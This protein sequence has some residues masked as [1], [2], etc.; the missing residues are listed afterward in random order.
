MSDPRLVGHPGTG[1]RAERP[2]RWG[3]SSRILASDAVLSSNATPLPSAG[4]PGALLGIEPVA[5][6][7]DMS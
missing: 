2:R 7:A 1:L 5:V 6:M 4:D 3:W